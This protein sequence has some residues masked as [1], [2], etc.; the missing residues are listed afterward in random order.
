MMLQTMLHGSADPDVQKAIKAQYGDVVEMAE[1]LVDDITLF[2]LDANRVDIE[3]ARESLLLAE[4]AINKELLANISN[5]KKRMRQVAGNIPS[6][7]TINAK[8]AE[9]VVELGK[10]SDENASLA[11]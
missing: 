7:K 3:K 1:S 5:H 11:I 8:G 4:Q 2:N 9:A 10:Y 6:V